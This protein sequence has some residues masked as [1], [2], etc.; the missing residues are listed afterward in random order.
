MQKRFV[1]KWRDYFD[2]CALKT[3]RNLENHG[4]IRIIRVL[5]AYYGSS[6]DLSIFFLRKYKFVIGDN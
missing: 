3:K 2:D 1:F 6:S 5:V 4:Y